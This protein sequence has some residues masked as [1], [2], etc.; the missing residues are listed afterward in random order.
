MT[1]NHKTLRGTYTALV[2]PMNQDGSVDHTALMDLVD[3]QIQE[4][5]QGLVPCGTTG[6]SA[7]LTAQERVD[8]ITEVVK[9]TAGR[10]PVIGGGG[11]H[12]TRVAIEHQKGLLDTGC[13]FALVVTPYYNKPTPRGLVE[14]YTALANAVDL[15]IIA[16]NVPGRTGVDMTP[17]VVAKI[18]EIDGVVGIK[19]ATGDVDRV[20][21]IR[22]STAED[23]ILLSG[24]D[25]SA[26]A[27]TFLGG[28]GVISV[29]SNIAPRQMSGMMQAALAGNTIAARTTHRELRALFDALFIESN[30]I[31]VK[32]A[33]AMMNRLQEIYRLPLC[34]MTPENRLQLDD[35]LRRG[36]YL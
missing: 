28:D 19:E 32:A 18:A 25:P 14:H 12:S 17:I 34:P 8:V 5:V 29:T 7:T 11:A 13:D 15:P 24:D 26:C 36:G 27:F 22:E 4:G 20:A 31:P 10:V 30:P 2:T 6:E 21:A 33:L 16:Y 1:M 23:F 3:W 35:A 9:K